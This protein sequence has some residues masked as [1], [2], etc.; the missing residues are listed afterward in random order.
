MKRQESS[1]EQRERQTGVNFNY[2][3]HMYGNVIHKKSNTVVVDVV[4][5]LRS[6]H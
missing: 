6:S 2:A 5:I 1:A 4:L 3:I